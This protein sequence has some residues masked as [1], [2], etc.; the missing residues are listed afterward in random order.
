MRD[1]IC[2]V[3]KRWMYK[4][5][6]NRGTKP[7]ANLSNCDSVRVLQGHTWEPAVVSH[8]ADAPRSYVIK[9]QNGYTI[10]RNRQ[11]LQDVRGPNNVP[12]IVCDVPDNV[13]ISGPAPVPESAPSAPRNDPV[14]APSVPVVPPTPISVR[15]S[16]RN[17]RLPSKFKDYD[18]K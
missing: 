2:C 6:Y 4:S 5:Y 13:S 11:H 8:T 3:A 18:M 15:R 10:R 1:K 7:L 16:A 9:T 17:T 12:N 14:S